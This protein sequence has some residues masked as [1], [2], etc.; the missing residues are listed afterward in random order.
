MGTSRSKL[1]IKELFFLFIKS[2]VWRRIWF[3]IDRIWFPI[4]AADTLL[5][6]IQTF[7]KAHN[8]G[9]QRTEQFPFIVSRLFISPHV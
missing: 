5:R 9:M 4:F 7:N 1:A 8:S 2:R 3:P 6:D